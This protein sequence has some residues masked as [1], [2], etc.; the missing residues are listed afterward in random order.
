MENNNL[1]SN[2][3]V[4][5]SANAVV[6]AIQHGDLIEA[7]RLW[8]NFHETEP[9]TIRE[10]YD[11]LISIQVDENNNYQQLD[12]NMR[13]QLELSREAP[14][15]PSESEMSALTNDQKFDVYNGITRLRGNASAESALDDNDRVILGLRNE[16][17]TTDNAGRGVYDD[18]I[19]VL[20]QESNG[21]KHIEEFNRATTEPT[22]QYDAHYRNDAN[23][24][25]RASDGEDI[26]NDNILDMGRLRS[27]NTFT[28]GA[29]T[30]ARPGGRGDNF[31]LRPTNDFVRDHGD[32][33]VERDTNGDGWFNSQDV[34][35]ITDLNNTFKIHA[36]SRNSTDS[37]GCQTIHR[38]DYDRFIT[39][40]NPPESTQNQWQYVLSSTEET[41]HIERVREQSQNIEEIETVPLSLNTGSEA[42]DL[43]LDNLEKSK[44]NESILENIPVVT[45]N[46]TVDLLLA[47]L[48]SSKDNPRGFDLNVML[49][50]AETQ[51]GKV[52]TELVDKGV[53]EMKI[54]AEA[55]LKLE[56]EQNTRSKSKSSGIGIG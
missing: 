18:R 49:A 17:Q 12:S 55:S 22:A 4:Q 1:R 2:S 7:Q 14:R 5:A 35:G 46:E 28:M 15:I 53:E 9:L 3:N 39:A 34:N 45:G 20:W 43:L 56:L 47:N 32:G 33:L 30:H 25:S 16:N 50:T 13:S 37:A 31:S 51:E 54:A 40:V 44:I 41:S 48:E 6:E 26:N 24:T 52:F 38:D 36:G 42:V 29:A 8:T 27:D 10:A 11:R 21:T 23:I 19:I